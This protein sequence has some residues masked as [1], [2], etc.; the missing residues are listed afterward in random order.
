MAGFG[1]YKNKV[2]SGQ[3]V[4]YWFQEHHAN[5]AVVAHPEG[6]VILDFDQIEVYYQ[7]CNMWPKLA[8][9]YTESTPRTGRHLFLRTTVPIPPGLVLVPGIEVLQECLVY[10]SKVEGL[11][12]RVVVAGEI[13]RGNVLEALQPFLLGGRDKLPLPPNVIAVGRPVAKK[14]YKNG[15][16]GFIAALKARWPI[17]DY[18]RY[19]EPKLLLTGRGRWLSGLC[20]WHDDHTPSLWVDVERNTWGCHTCQIG[21]DILDWHKRRMGNNI[22]DALCDLARYKVEVRG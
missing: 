19:F 11:Y 7:F 15:N 4:R 22:T 21:G 14:G 18:M 1:F 8:K 3:K 2:E 9:S 20:P 13:L 10:P 12:Y 17:L 16:R 6:G 5:L